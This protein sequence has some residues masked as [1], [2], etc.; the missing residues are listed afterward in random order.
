MNALT[1][2]GERVRGFQVIVVR[3]EK[4]TNLRYPVVCGREALLLMELMEKRGRATIAET[5]SYGVVEDVT[6]EEM[7]EFA[8]YFP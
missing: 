4:K 5:E 8:P 1:R 2:T 3:P 6:L 7:R